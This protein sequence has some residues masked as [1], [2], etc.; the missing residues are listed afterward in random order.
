MMQ[1]TGKSGLAGLERC[2]MLWTSDTLHE[3][4]LIVESNRRV[5]TKTLGSKLSSQ[6]AFHEYLTLIS[7]PYL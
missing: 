4:I 1:S 6:Y 7:S 5:S 2:Q 3:E